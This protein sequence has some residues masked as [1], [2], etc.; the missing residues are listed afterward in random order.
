MKSF[1]TKVAGV[2][3]RMMQVGKFLCYAPFR[4]EKM[5]VQEGQQTV[6]DEQAA[7][8]YAATYG[9]WPKGQKAITWVWPPYCGP[10]T[11]VM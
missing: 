7:E 1:P 10:N 4:G 3:I 8:K 11:W 9:Q 2:E 6:G 5:L